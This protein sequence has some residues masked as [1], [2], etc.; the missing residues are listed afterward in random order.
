[1]P[2]VSLLNRPAYKTNPI[3]TKEIESQV[4]DLLE[5]CWVQKSLSPYVV[6]VLL[7]KDGNDACVVIVR[8][9]TTSLS[10]VNISSQD[11]MT[12]W[13]SYM[14]QLFSPKLISKVAT[15]KFASERVM[16][17]KP[18]LRPSLVFMNG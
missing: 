17:E 7:V 9:S 3:E 12:C 14:E 16:N 15:V 11:L 8:L 1:M 10:S 18:L 13:M 4:N 5:K 2:K 6:P